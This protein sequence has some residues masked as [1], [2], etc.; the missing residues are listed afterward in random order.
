MRSS[1]HLPH[2]T[3]ATP[4]LKLDEK[5]RISTESNASANQGGLTA[6]PVISSPCSTC[7]SDTKPQHPAPAPFCDT[8]A[9]EQFPPLFTSHLAMPLLNEA[10]LPR[11]PAALPAANAGRASDLL[12][13]PSPADLLRRC[14]PPAFPPHQPAHRSPAGGMPSGTITSAV[15]QQPAAHCPANCAPPPVAPPPPPP[16]PPGLREDLVAVRVTRGGRCGRPLPLPTPRASL[17]PHPVFLTP[18]HPPI[19]HPLLAL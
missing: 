14:Q 3:D 18:A 1:I 13:E 10:A 8:H 4:Q 9:A 12:A 16:P 17:R 11:H 6:P 2:L 5:Q 7:I 15:Q 19:P